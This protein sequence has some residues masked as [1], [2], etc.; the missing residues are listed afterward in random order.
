MRMRLSVSLADLKKHALELA[1]SADLARAL[2]AG[3]IR[4][5]CR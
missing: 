4:P 3:T 2:A 1:L 5:G